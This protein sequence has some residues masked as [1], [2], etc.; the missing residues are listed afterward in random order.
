MTKSEKVQLFTLITS[1]MV[2]QFCRKGRRAADIDY[3]QLWTRG[4]IAHIVSLFIGLD[5]E[6]E[7]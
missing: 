2:E 5:G 4:L 6:Q 1:L 3:V 7:A